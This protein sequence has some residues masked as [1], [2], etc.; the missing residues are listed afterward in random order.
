MARF[1]LYRSLRGRSQPHVPV[2]I[3]RRIAVGRPSEARH[4]VAKRTHAHRDDLAE[5]PFRDQFPRPLI[6]RPGAL[7]RSDLHDALVSLGHV[8]HPAAFADEQRQRF[9]DVH[10]LA[11][12]AGQHGLQ[13]VPVVRRRD[14][15]RL[16]IL[17]VEQAAK[18]AVAL[19]RFA[20]YWSDSYHEID[21]KDAYAF[22]KAVF[23]NGLEIIGDKVAIYCWHAHKRAGVIQKVWEEL[24]ILDHQEIVWIKPTPVFGRVFW[25]FKH[26][27]CM[28][29]WRKG[30]VPEHDG[31][32]TISSVWEIDYD[33]KGRVVGNDHPTQKPLEIFARPM[34]KHTKARRSLL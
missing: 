7:L 30:S 23:T 18:V 13:G 17:V 31:D 20:E 21:I 8:D 25:H 34:R 1:G 32:Q 27:P 9:L 26:E 19:G 33:G 22:Y 5:F 3:G 11:G 24:G 16:D 12:G 6:V 4:D 14:H 28:M 15:D 29:G 2:E 10:V